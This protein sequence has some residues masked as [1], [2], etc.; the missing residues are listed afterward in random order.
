MESILTSTK[1]IAGLDSSYDHFNPEII[2][3]IN[4]V[5]LNLK[6]IGI[7][8]SE[9]FIISDETDMW[10]DFIPT[11]AVLREAVKEFM[12][13]KV[14]LKFDP[15]LNSAVLESL[16]N[17]IKE[18]EWRLCTEGELNTSGEEDT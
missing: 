15:P 17:N 14:R 13:M 9:G 6:Q 3:Y 10:K 12:G 7:G 2:M 16:K 18:S 11:N 5:F 4:G 1:K 8:P